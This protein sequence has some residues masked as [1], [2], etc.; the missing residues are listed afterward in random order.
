M[1][2]SVTSRCVTA[3][4]TEGWIVA[5][6]PT[7]AAREPRQRVGPFE[8]ETGRIDLDEVR[9]APA[10]DPPGRLPRGDAAR[11]SSRERDP[12]RA[13]RRGDRARRA[14][15]AATIP[16]CRIAPPKRCFSRH[17]CSI[18]SREPARRAPS[19]QPSPFE[20]QSV[21]VSKRAAIAEGATPSATDALR[22]R[23]PSRCTASPSSRAVATTS[24]SASSGQTRPPE[25]LCVFS[26]DEHRGALVGDL[27]AR[28]GGGAHLLRRELP[29]LARQ[30]RASRGRRA[31][32]RRR[33]RR[34]RRARAARR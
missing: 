31:R 21:T 34:S 20:R 16:A 30:R 28:L 18:S 29:A 3:R 17:A 19:G 13:A 11:A 5:E 27:R 24:S 7:P 23:A 9:L 10:R 1:S 15:A 33:T 8:A 22:S 6:R 32:Q 26:S 12:P 2:S 14:P 25:L 4:M